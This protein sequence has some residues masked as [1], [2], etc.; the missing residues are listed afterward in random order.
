MA[1]RTDPHADTVK[2]TN[3]QYLVDKII[4][5]K[6]YNDAYWK[7]HCFG[8]TSADPLNPFPAQRLERAKTALNNCL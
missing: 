1:N 6:I 4:R 2:G 7:E 5:N 8:S 3:P